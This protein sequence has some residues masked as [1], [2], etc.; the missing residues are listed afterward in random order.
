MRSIVISVGTLSLSF[1]LLVLMSQVALADSTQ[2]SFVGNDACASCHE[3]QVQDWTNSH[4]DL[5]MQEV[6]EKT[7]L[8]DF[9]NATF[10]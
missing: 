2:N 9:D 10:I 1:L 4:H 3:A 8:G 7:V 5:A 6:N